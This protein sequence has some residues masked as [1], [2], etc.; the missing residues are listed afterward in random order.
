MSAQELESY[1]YQLKQIELLLKEDSTNEEWLKL[2]ADLTRVIQLTESLNKPTT[3][4]KNKP[5]WK[6]GDTVL[7]QWKTDGLYYN[8]TIKTLGPNMTVV[9]TDF[10]DIETVHPQELLPLAVVAKEPSTTA[11]INTEPSS[12]SPSTA[13]TPPADPPSIKASAPSGGTVTTGKRPASKV[14]GDDANQDS[15]GARVNKRKPKGPTVSQIAREKQSSWLEFARKSSKKKGRG[16]AINSKSI[17]ASPDTVKGKVGVVGSGKPM[18][19]NRTRHKRP[20]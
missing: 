14:P 9:F 10:G 18:T 13:K 8:A 4:A 15:A 16:G 11:T 7:A 1:Q 12:L 19:E 6:V 20:T 2:K 17:F 3:S 5:Q